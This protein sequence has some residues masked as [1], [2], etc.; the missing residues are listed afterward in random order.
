M[1]TRIRFALLALALGASGALA[2]YTPPRD[3][4]SQQASDA[5]PAMPARSAAAGAT[6]P[7]AVEDVDAARRLFR[8]L[9]RNGDGCLRDD[10]LRSERGRQA[11]W[12]AVDRNRDGCISRD[13]FTV[14]RPR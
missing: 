4:A 13:E 2:Q 7:R 14:V 8:E 10:E 11:N 6:A 5:T 12:A 1:P 3:T 9:D